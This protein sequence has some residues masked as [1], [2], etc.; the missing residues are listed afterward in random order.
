MRF[1]NLK[2]GVVAALISVT[3][4]HVAAKD[5]LNVSYDPTRELYEDINTQFSAYWKQH[6]GQNINFKQ[7]LFRSERINNNAYKMIF[8]E[9]FQH[10][11]LSMLLT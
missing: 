2:L 4:F 10:I 9:N 7:S 6:T 8:Q 3:S 1:S 5:F 11:L